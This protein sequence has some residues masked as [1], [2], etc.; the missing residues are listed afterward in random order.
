MCDDGYG[1]L[2]HTTMSVMPAKCCNLLGFVTERRNNAEEV[3][4]AGEGW[5]HAP[6][7]H[8]S[9]NKYEILEPHQKTH[10]VDAAILPMT[11][12]YLFN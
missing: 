11:C 5:G 12:H 8:G 3:C 6:T 4:G 10:K 1:I 9:V 7:T 2:L